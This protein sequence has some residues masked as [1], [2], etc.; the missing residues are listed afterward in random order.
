MLCLYLFPVGILTL[1]ESKNL[2]SFTS[3]AMLTLTIQA[4]ALQSFPVY[5]RQEAIPWQSFHSLTGTPQRTLRLLAS[6]VLGSLFQPATWTLWLTTTLLTKSHAP[7]ICIPREARQGIVPTG[8]LSSIPTAYA[9]PLA[10]NIQLLSAE[11]KQVSGASPTMT[12]GLTRF[13]AVSS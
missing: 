10:R 12:T 1:L 8:L 5:F 4:L 6:L 11:L 9:R 2:T 7:R 13:V 3:L